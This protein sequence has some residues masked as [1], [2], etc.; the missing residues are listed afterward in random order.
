[1]PTIDLT[2]DE[3][4]VVTAA[5]RHLVDEDKF[6]HAPRLDPLKSAMTKFDAA[7]AN[8]ANP[9]AES[10]ASPRRQA[11]AAIAAGQPR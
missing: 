2:D 10:T 8:E 9:A 5:I 3:H 11:A 7:T 1:M 4:A 6:P